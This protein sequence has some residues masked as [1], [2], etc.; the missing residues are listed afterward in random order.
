MQVIVI[1]FLLS[2]FLTNEI[3]LNTGDPEPMFKVIIEGT[4]GSGKM[5]PLPL[6]GFKKPALIKK[7]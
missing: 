6:H 1:V 7:K 2:F 3:T 4:E 5:G